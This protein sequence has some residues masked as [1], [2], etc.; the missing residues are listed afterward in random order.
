MSKLKI[1]IVGVKNM[2]KKHLKVLQNYFADEVEIAGIVNSTPESSQARAEELDVPY[3]NTLS[4]ITK[5]NV[6]GVIICTPATTHLAVGCEILQKG[7]PCLME[8]PLAT[9]QKECQQLI[10]IAA[11]NNVVLMVG[12]NT[13]YD[14]SVIMLK[15]LAQKPIKS[16]E[17][18]RTSRYVNEG[19]KDVSVIQELMIHDLGIM[20]A[21]ISAPMTNV[22]VSRQPQYDW[23]EN[24][25]LEIDFADGAHV[26][27]EGLIA[28]K[29][30]QRTMK[31]VDAKE[32]V[33][34]LA[35]LESALFKNGQMLR[36]GGNMLKNELANFIA[37]IKGREKP[38]VTGEEGL[39]NVTTCIELE[40]YLD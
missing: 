30:V 23:K 8:K 10:D 37:V 22:K 12:H 9:T 21:L 24:A 17:G 6:D 39:K 32:D 7:I 18:I 38:F 13:N 3:F 25:L 31:V 28:D 27:L 29:D 20:N 15:E 11:H 4:E 34:E 16:I 36:I 33:Y 1:A 19:K 35:F 2:G 14:S 5:D 40:K 26:K